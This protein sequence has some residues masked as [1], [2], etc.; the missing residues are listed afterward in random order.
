MAHARALPPYAKKGDVI[1]AFHFNML[2]D[3][4]RALDINSG[5]GISIKK[6]SSG[7]TISIMAD[8]GGSGSSGSGGSGSS[9]GH[10]FDPTISAGSDEDHMSVT[11]R[12]GTING[13]IPSNMSDTYDVSNAGAL[14]LVLHVTATD[15]EIDGATL[16]I[17]SDAPPALPVLLGAPP[18][19]FD[20]MLGIFVDGVWFR[21]A[22]P[23]SLTAVGV[24][25][26]RTDKVA[27][28]PGTLPYDIHYTWA[29]S[30]A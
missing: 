8:Q 30:A 6:S 1:Q 29:L 22:G 20:Y 11:L 25:M 13:L 12:P 9:S 27:P 3:L 26:F 4:I 28:S 15:G 5:P 21:T 24:E 19:S 17:E 23:E 2:I 7:L 10:P 18:A 14:Y 16:S